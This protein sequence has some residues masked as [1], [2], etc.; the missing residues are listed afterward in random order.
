MKQLSLFEIEE[1]EDVIDDIAS[2]IDEDIIS[3]DIKI[4]RICKEEKSLDEFRLD[5]GKP[6][7]KCNDCAREYQKDLKE[8]H[9][10]APPKPER[11]ECCNKVPTKWVCDHYPNSRIFRGWVCWECNNAAG[12][13]G[14]SYEG[15]VNLLNY[16]YSRRSV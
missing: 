7:S 10:K 9:K 4:C 12:S 11:C 2:D 13:V 15:A 16:L 5:R 14:D 8:V 1:T 3:E 6:Y